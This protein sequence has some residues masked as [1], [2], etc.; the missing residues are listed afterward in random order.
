MFL[1]RWFRFCN[2]CSRV[3]YSSC[4]SGKGW[5][6]QTGR[7]SANATVWQLCGSVVPRR[8]FHGNLGDMHSNESVQKYVQ[9]LMEEYRSLSKKLQHAH[10]SES[11]RKVLLKRHTELL[12]VAA[13]FESVQQALKDQE[14]VISLLHSKSN[15]AKMQHSLVTIPGNSSQGHTSVIF[16]VINSL[17]IHYHSIVYDFAQTTGSSSV[18]DEDKLFTQQL[19]EEEEQISQK[20]LSLRNDVGS[21]SGEN[22]ESC[23]RVF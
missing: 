14:E 23:F 22:R 18:D 10:L 15:L 5:R 13:V 1:N 6:T 19:K 3:V 2:K 20:L 12:P 21:D 7:S 11:D 9:Q 16:N 17:S 8:H 4:G